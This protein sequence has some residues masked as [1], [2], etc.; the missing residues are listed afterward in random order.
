M[1]EAVVQSSPGGQ[2]PD[3]TCKMVL[4]HVAAFDQQVTG[5]AVAGNGR[6]FV[7]FPRREE[8]VAVSVAEVRQDSTLHSFPN[9]GWNA[10][11]NAEPLSLADHFV[12]VQSVTVDLQGFLWV[13]DPAAPG[14]KFNKPGGV[15][16][17]KFDLASDALV[18]SIVFDTAAAPQ[19]T[20]LND[21][22]VSPDGRFAYLTD[23]GQRGAL[24]VV[25]LSGG[26]V[27]RVLDGHPVTQPEADVVVHADGHELRKADGRPTLFAADGIALDVEG[28]WLY[29]QALTGRTLYR[30][31][32]SALN[33]PDLPPAH[34]EA[35]I[36]RVGTTGVADG[37]W[38]DRA[39]NLYV[40]NPEDDGLKL[41]RP[42]G[43]MATQIQ[44]R[45][46]AL[47]G[48]PGGRAGRRDLGHHLANPGHGPLPQAGQRASGALR[49]VA[50]ASRRPGRTIRRT[51][52][53]SGNHAHLPNTAPTLNRRLET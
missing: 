45:R 4:E 50:P 42:D 8:D 48:Q 27:R 10:Y 9:T 5:V 44:D 29:W 3:P 47:A 16:L 41:R 11:R 34:L 25:E 33:D 14:N 31:P 15:K 6:V 38:M 19:G 43:S 37:L 40:T 17:L 22:R 20:Y 53:A 1:T 32:A 13:L 7:C 35:A 30:L 21:V 12:C 49:P 26:R 24:L 18:Q 2:A 46:A 36:E 28:Q 51:A 52:S 23:S 39:G